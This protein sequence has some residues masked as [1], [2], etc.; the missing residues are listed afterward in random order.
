VVFGEPNPWV[1][2][3]SKVNPGWFHKLAGEEPSYPAEHWV[4]ILR[5]DADG[6]NWR[7]EVWKYL[8]VVF[9]DYPD[10][11]PIRTADPSDPLVVMD[12]HGGNPALVSVRD[13]M[14]DPVPT[15]VSPDKV[16]ALFAQGTDGEGGIQETQIWTEV[17]TWRANPDGSVTTS[18]PGLSGAPSS[19]AADASNR[20]AGDVVPSSRITAYNVD[21][22]KLRQGGKTGVR[23]VAWARAQNYLGQI[24]E[25]ARITLSWP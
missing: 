25:T 24:A 9:P 18:G 12:A 15:H 17:T 11:V 21:F 2:K 3:V 22:P 16:I 4:G 14:S 13:G 23:V 20:T 19:S 6:I 7:D 1:E 10:E 8:R 5:T